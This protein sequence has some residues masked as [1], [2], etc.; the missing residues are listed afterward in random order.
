M[1]TQNP[2]GPDPDTLAMARSV[3]SLQRRW[4]VL[5]LLG[6]VQI[7]G[8]VIALAVPTA[9]SLA[10]AIVFGAVFVVSGV[11]QVVHAFGVRRWKGVTLQALGG[12]LY[13][14][15]GIL[16]LVFPLSGVL[17]LTIVVA[18][19]LIADGAVRTFLAYRLKPLQGWG[20]FMAAGIASTALGI[21]LLIGWPLTGFWAIGMLLGVSLVFSGV[22]NSVLAIMFRKGTARDLEREAVEAAH[23][24][25]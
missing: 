21:M 24:H 15:A 13:V 1:V 23:R 9:A 12:L 16:V 4:L 20:W 11:F 5:L 17:T 2:V 25:A 8:G 14:A 19:L 22:T 10:A 18:T 6:I 7:I 3:T